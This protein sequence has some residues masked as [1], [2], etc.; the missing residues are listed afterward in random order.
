MT[1]GCDWNLVLAFLVFTNFGAFI[2]Y[3]AEC[4][5]TNTGTSHHCRQLP[6]LFQKFQQAWFR[7]ISA[8]AISYCG[9]GISHMDVDN[10]LTGKKIPQKR[11]LNKLFVTVL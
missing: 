2:Q 4:K 11:G 3:L 8:D 7:V 10:K 1:C 5:V 9:F 6:I